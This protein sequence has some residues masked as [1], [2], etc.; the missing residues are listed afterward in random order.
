SLIRHC[1][2]RDYNG[3]GISFQQ[4]NDVTV[5]GCTVEHCAGFGL[6]PGS[7]SQRPTVRNCRAVANDDDGLFF[8]WRVRG[9]IAEG[10]WLEGNGGH[11]ISL[12]HKDSDDVVRGN[13][14]VGNGRGGVFWRA[15]AEPMAAHRTIFEDNVVRDNEGYGLFVDGATQGTVIR[16]N[17]IE[18]SGSGRQTAGIRVGKNAGEVVLE[19]NT[20][21]AQ[22]DLVDERK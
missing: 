10:N 4:S 5:E 20:I 6:H 22:Q 7:G 3:D 15:E 19:R 12:G 8:C 16:G 13:T 14:I 11:G 21:K 18:D 9:G 2:V 17:T 1:E